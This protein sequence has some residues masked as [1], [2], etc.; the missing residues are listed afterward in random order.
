MNQE[1][2]TSDIVWASGEYLNAPLPN[3]GDDFE[4]WEAEKVLEWIDQNKIEFLEDVGNR[5]IA[6]MILSTAVNFRDAMRHEARIIL[7]E[8][9]DVL[10]S[11]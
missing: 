2:R 3:W 8:L 5:E 9:S 7:K 6:H 4:K 11:V 10:N 1:V